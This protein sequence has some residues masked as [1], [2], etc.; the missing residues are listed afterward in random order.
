VAERY[1][2]R[3]FEDARRFASASE[4]FLLEREV[5]HCLILGLLPVLAREGMQQAFMGLV[6]DAGGA[7]VLVALRTPPHRLILSEFADGHEPREVVEPLVAAVATTPGVLGAP[8]SSGAF[9]RA[10]GEAAGQAAELTQS[11]RVYV[12]TE[13]LDAGTTEGTM[14]RGGADDL[15]LLADWL[16]AFRLEATPTDPRIG[17]EAAVEDVKRDLAAAGGGLWLWQVDGRPVSM[18]GARGPTRNGIR[19][20]PV[21]T[22]PQLRGNGYAGALTAALT[23]ELLAGG[24]RHVT[25]FADLG[26]PVANHIYQKIGYRPAA[27]QRVYGFR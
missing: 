5:E 8:S 18:A 26:N 1:S 22:P 14:V 13:V 16:L 19:I 15:G 10:W 2:L 17:R 4:A 25:L 12:C 21:Y 23:R 6:Q 20:G 3:S 24:R 9:A 11:E 27:E 7:T